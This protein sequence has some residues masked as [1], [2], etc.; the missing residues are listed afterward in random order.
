MKAEHRKQLETNELAKRVSSTVESAKLHPQRIGVIVAVIVLLVA[1]GIGW[2]YYS[3]AKTANLSHLWTRL[4]ASA[5]IKD[6]EEI[7]NDGRGTVP[8]RVARF[9]LARRLLTQLGLDQLTAGTAEQR[10]AAAAN[11][12]KARSE[13]EG[14]YKEVSGTNEI[15]LAREALLGQAKAEEALAG[16]PKA[17]NP[18]QARGSTEKALSLYREVVQKY[19][20]SFQAK[21]AEKRVKEFEANR[22]KIDQFY[23]QLREALAAKNEPPKPPTMPSLESPKK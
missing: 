14:L 16:V 2:Y 9:Q 15:M 11:I 3:S 17:D 4:N 19:P 22:G 10:T 1:G 6:L 18:S 8:G 21:E 7:A 23:N 12:E 20:D 13:Y 5:D